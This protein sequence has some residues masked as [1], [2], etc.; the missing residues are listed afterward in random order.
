MGFISTSKISFLMVPFERLPRKI[1]PLNY[2]T[3]CVNSVY[4]KYR[5]NYFCPAE[6][7]DDEQS[8]CSPHAH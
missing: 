1:V 2:V 7:V 8:P 5:A 3:F 6:G 4:Y